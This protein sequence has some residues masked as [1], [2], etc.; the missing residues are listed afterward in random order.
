MLPA[1]N[2]D[3]L[4]CCQCRHNAPE[5]SEYV[6]AW[7]SRHLS[8]C[9]PQGCQPGRLLFSLFFFLFSVA[10]TALCGPPEHLSG[11]HS[12]IVVHL[13]SFYI[14]HYL[15]VCVRLDNLVVNKILIFPS[16]PLGN[17]NRVS[18]GVTEGILERLCANAEHNE[19]S[20]FRLLLLRIT[21]T[22]KGML[23]FQLDGR[24]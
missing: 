21:T 10:P 11:R 23:D 3:G 18:W 12:S 8:R 7:L 22:K 13:H 5:L 9:S 15:R 17:N 6:Y 24:L 19:S 1:Q 2:H 20:T 4:C 14:P 16:F